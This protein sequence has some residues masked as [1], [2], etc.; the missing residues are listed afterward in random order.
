MPT[1]EALLHAPFGHPPSP[2]HCRFQA[3]AKHQGS[4]KRGFSV[5]GCL[6]VSE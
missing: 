1:R 6:W 2:L 4:L 5:S 3:A